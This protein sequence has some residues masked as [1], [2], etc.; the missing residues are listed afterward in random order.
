[1]MLTV[2]FV[3]TVFMTLQQPNDLLI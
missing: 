2:T 3:A 1:M